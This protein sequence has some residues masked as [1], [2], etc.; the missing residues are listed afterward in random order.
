MEEPG[1]ATKERALSSERVNLKNGALGR[2]KGLGPGSNPGHL[3]ARYLRSRLL[4]YSEAR[5]G[6]GKVCVWLVWQGV[7]AMGS[8][9]K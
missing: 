2:G 3:K 9:E 6:A 1:G 8:Q 5:K 4:P 7:F